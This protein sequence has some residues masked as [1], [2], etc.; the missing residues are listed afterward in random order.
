MTDVTLSVP[1]DFFTTEVWTA[2]G[3][4]THYVLFFIHIQSRKVYLAGIMPN[5]RDAW[6]RQVA[7]NL[8]MAGCDIA[9]KCRYLIRDRDTKFTVG[10]DAIFRAAVSTSR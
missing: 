9:G 3:L 10:F 8:T 6:M 4:V 2:F 1:T 7:R 5:P